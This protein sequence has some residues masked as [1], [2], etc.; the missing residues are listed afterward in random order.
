MITL[1][2]LR[3]ATGCTEEN[4]AKYLDHINMALSAFDIRSPSCIAGFLSQVG[5]ESAGL[6][7]VVENLN[8]KVSALLALFGTRRISEADAARYGRN[9]ATGQRADQEAIANLIY[10]GEWGRRNL[11]NTEQGDGWR[12]RGRGLKQLTGRDNYTRCGRDVSEILGFDIVAEPERLAEPR[13]AALSAGWFWN[14]KRGQGIDEAA[15]AGDVA[16]MTKLINGGDLGLPQRQ[17]LFGKALAQS[18]S[19]LA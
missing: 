16:R 15:E 12:F 1:D 6:A 14:S 7:T 13:A 17:A 3:A 4:G 5:H 18:G 8:Y 10:G 9:D 2:Y 11:G 19:L